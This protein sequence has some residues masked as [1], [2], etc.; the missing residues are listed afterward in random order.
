MKRL[1]IVLA[2]AF[3]FIGHATVKAQAQEATPV[4]HQHE[5]GDFWAELG[6]LVLDPAHWGQELIAE[7]VF[8]PL[9][10]FLVERLIHSHRVRKGM[11]HHNGGDRIE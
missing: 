5:E 4:V 7:L 10:F 2:L 6:G 3:L 11:L 9:E 8:F 1:A